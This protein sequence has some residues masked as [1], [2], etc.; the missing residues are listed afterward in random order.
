MQT[1][2]L[3]YIYLLYN[4]YGLRWPCWQVLHYQIWRIVFPPF[5]HASCLP[6]SYHNFCHTEECYIYNIIKYDALYSDLSNILPVLYNCLGHV[7]KCSIYKHYQISCIVF[8]PFHHVYLFWIVILAI[9]TSVILPSSVP[10]PVKLDWVSLI[11]NFSNPAGRLA[12]QK[13]SLV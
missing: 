3:H 7:D 4:L 11:F 1:S 6:V 5:H 12:Y 9:I 13:S 8:T 2:Y 10:A